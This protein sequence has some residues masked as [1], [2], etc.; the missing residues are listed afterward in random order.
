MLQRYDQIVHLT[1]GPVVRDHETRLIAV[2]YLILVCHTA[3]VLLRLTVAEYAGVT[4]C[5]LRIVATKEPRF[6]QND[7][8][9]D[10]GTE[11]QEEA[12]R[13]AQWLIFRL[14]IF[15]TMVLMPF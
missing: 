10:E 4:W 14:R 1:L 12:S 15:R 8:V 5:E 11:E 9:V 13:A 3:L 7:H 6:K 2:Q